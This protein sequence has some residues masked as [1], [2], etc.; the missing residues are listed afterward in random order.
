VQGYRFL[1]KQSVIDDND[2]DENK[3][4]IISNKAGNISFRFD[5]IIWFVKVNHVKSNH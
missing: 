4:P 3:L 1:S 5:A 2:A